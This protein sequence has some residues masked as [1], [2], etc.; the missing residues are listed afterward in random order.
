MRMALKRLY[1]VQQ[2]SVRALFKNIVLSYEHCYPICKHNYIQHFI[3]H[4]RVIE[5]LEL[6]CFTGLLLASAKF[7]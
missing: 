2:L 7:F 6:P 4:Y 1:C 3:I 5:R